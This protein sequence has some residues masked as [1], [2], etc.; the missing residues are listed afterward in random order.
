MARPPRDHPVETP[1]PPAW[2]A[3]S[4]RLAVNLKRGRVRKGGAFRPSDVRRLLIAQGFKCAITGRPF[5]LEGGRRAPWRASLDRIDNA[6]PYQRGNVRLVATV[7][8]MAMGSWGEGTLRELAALLTPEYRPEA[9]SRTFVD[10]LAKAL[11]ALPANGSRP[12]LPDER[13]T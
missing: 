7:V 9:E 2:Q 10:R 6:K 1:V 4:I 8:N 13:S 5:D 11:K 12:T 3:E